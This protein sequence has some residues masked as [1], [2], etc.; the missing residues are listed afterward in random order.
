MSDQDMPSWLLED[1]EDEAPS[2]DRRWGRL[3]LIVAAV[4]PWV[5]VAAIIVG[6]SGVGRAGSDP[7]PTAASAAA[8]GTVAAQETPV[9]Q[10]SAPGPA[11]TDEGSTVLFTSPARTRPTTSDAAAMAMVAARAWLTDV[12]PSLSLSGDGA[13]D[14][15]EAGTSGLTYVEH[16]AVEGV[17]HPAP[18]HAV[19][20]VLAVVLEVEDGDYRDVTVRRLAVPLR[21]DADGARPA[22][23]PWW[24]GAPKI[25]PVEVAGETVDDPELAA[26]AGAA[27]AEAGYADVEILRLEKT[28]G[29]PWR[30]TAAAVA[31]F[32]SDRQEHVVWLRSHQGGF[33]VAGAL[34]PATEKDES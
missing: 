11:V 19:A 29:W 31:P 27:L 10:T 7:A 26:E 14:Q 1:T 23:E 24:L 34:P 8:T 12:G 9:E 16:L 30:I 4:L 32:S 2:R 20:S 25:A 28:D 17:D 22:G 33:V 21:F 18:G 3:A 5:V 15:P 6:R 13:T